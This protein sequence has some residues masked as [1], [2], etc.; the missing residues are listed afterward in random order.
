MI[1]LRFLATLI[2]RIK[3]YNESE[4]IYRKV[5]FVPA[6]LFGIEI[7]DTIKNI[8]LPTTYIITYTAT[9]KCHWWN[10]TVL[11][12]PASDNYEYIT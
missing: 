2:F 8:T 1:R 12:N 9:K 5:F 7:S 11:F 6:D 3:K 10:Y 4:N